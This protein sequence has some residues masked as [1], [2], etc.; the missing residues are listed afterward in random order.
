MSLHCYLWA[1][2]KCRMWIT[3][4]YSDKDIHTLHQ[5]KSL[6]PKKIFA[7]IEIMVPKKSADS[8]AVVLMWVCMKTVFVPE[9]AAGLINVFCQTTC[10]LESEGQLEGINPKLPSLCNT[11]LGGVYPNWPIGV[12]INTDPVSNVW[13]NSFYLLPLCCPDNPGLIHAVQSWITMSAPP[14]I[15]ALWKLDRIENRHKDTDSECKNL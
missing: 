12:Q 3:R 2:G 14:T 13:E 11:N 8:G 10:S 6:R 4:L 5:I 7:Q 9:L 15:S 1:I